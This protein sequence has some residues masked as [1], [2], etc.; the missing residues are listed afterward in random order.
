[1]LAEHA[2][3][4]GAD[5]VSSLPPKGDAAAIGAYYAELAAGSPLPLILYY[6]PKASPHAFS[7]PEQL[8]EICDLPNVLGVK[9]TDFNFYLMQRLI[10]RGN[11][12]F[13]GY[14]EALA[15]GL[16]MGAQGGIGSTYNIMPEAYL[17]L[18][19]AA[20]AAEWETARRWQTQINDV[21]TTLLN[22]PFFPA[23]RAVM[24]EKGF[25]CGP[26][27]S[28]EELLPESQRVALLADLDRNV[29]REIATILSLGTA[30]AL[31]NPR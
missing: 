5:A 16:L 27:M 3:R 6:F 18:Y 31:I 7:D 12:V 14:D 28:G 25:N 10:K 1:M 26:M 22:Y 29:S 30:G 11:L 8:L 23:L 17:S 4:H 2:A 9:F 20:M 13:N 19:R 24:K 21:I 15:A